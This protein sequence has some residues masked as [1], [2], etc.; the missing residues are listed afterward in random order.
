MNFPETEG[1]VNDGVLGK[2]QILLL[3][4]PVW[5]MKSVVALNMSHSLVT[6]EDFLCRYKVPQPLNVLF[7]DKEIGM[8][9]FNERVKL[10]YPEEKELP[11][12]FWV[13][14]KEDKDILFKIDQKGSLKPLKDMLK[15]LK[16]NVVIMDCLNP[17]LSEEEGE[18]TFSSVADNI[19]MLQFEFAAFGL[20]FIIIHHMREV[21]EG[22]DPLSWYNIRGH[23]KLV[24]WP[25]TRITM[26]RHRKKGKASNELSFRFMLR[27][28][29][30][31]D[32]LMLKVD[33][34]LRLLQGKKSRFGESQ[35]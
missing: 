33:E 8:K 16:P 2:G 12:N 5:S 34:R 31:Q 20:S 14:S 25:D 4:A 26:H 27:H 6:A 3:A 1:Y 10:F 30:Q 28:G 13:V 35:F 24:D 11:D 32:D 17:F 22:A 23:G 18:Q 29:A 15:S 21:Q 7:L 9:G 19:A